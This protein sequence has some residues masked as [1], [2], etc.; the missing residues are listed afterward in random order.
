ML[1]YAQVYDL[2]D[3]ISPSSWWLTQDKEVFDH[4]GQVFSSIRAHISKLGVIYQIRKMSSQRKYSFS[5]KPIESVLWF[6]L[7]QKAYPR[8]HLASQLAMGTFYTESYVLSE[9][10]THLAAFIC[11]WLLYFFFPSSPTTLGSADIEILK[12]KGGIILPLEP[13]MDLLC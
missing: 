3:Q 13:T 5:L 1:L 11:S 6:S 4:H 9:R 10:A 7:L 12:P 8:I 2:V